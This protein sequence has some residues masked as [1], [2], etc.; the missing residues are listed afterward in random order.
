ML[1][2][3]DTPAATKLLN[4]VEHALAGEPNSRERQIAAAVVGGLRGAMAL[5]A[6]MAEARESDAMAH[7]WFVAAARAAAAH[8]RARAKD[9]L[10]HA[11]R[12][13]SDLEFP[14]LEARAAAA[15]S[16]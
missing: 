9:C 2:Q 10:A 7:G 8:D 15:R 5:G 6:V 3:G 14:Y 4:E 16:R 13:A 1:L 12:A 11:A